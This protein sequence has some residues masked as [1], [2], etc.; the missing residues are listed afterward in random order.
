MGILPIIF[1]LLVFTLKEL[2]LQC[3]ILGCS[4]NNC[5]YERIQFGS[6]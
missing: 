4:I 5:F 2:C 6:F 1:Y 3:L